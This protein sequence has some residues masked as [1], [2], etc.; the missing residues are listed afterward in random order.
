MFS[1]QN[2]TPICKLLDCI[3]KIFLYSRGFSNA[4]EFAWANN[5]SNFNATWG[6]LT[7]IGEEYQKIDAD[8]KNAYP[9]IRW[10]H[11]ASVFTELAAD[12]KTI[13]RALIYQI[14]QHELIALK[15]ALVSMIDK[16]DDNAG[17]LDKVLNSPY[18]Q[19]IQYLRTK[20]K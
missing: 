2:L 6:L 15:D 18:Y 11:I 7:V 13:D 5:E 14:S 10:Q 19:H 17:I 16:I 4:Y 3:E 1:R 8:L 9:K 20:L 12:Y